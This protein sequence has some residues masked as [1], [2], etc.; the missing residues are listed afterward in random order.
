MSSLSEQYCK[1]HK[2]SSLCIQP[3]L[4]EKKVEADRLNHHHTASILH[5]CFACL[6]LLLTSH[7]FVKD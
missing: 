3:N 5:T 2:I 6:V 1:L 4:K 7:S